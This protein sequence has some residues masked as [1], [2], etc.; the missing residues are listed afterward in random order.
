MKST[1]SYRDSSLILGALA[2]LAL[3]CSNSSGSSTPIIPPDEVDTAQGGSS[4]GAESPTLPPGTGDFAMTGDDSAVCATATFC[5]GFEDAAVDLAPGGVWSPTQ[6]NGTV[7]VD[8]SRPGDYYEYE[9]THPA[10]RART[11]VDSPLPKR[12]VASEPLAA[13]SANRVPFR[14]RSCR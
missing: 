7:R 2:G 10:L 6:N 13:H 5:D 8:A 1:V 3:A 11:L 12:G 9:W 14:T 4:S